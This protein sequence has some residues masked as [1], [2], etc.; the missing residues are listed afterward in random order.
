MYIFINLAKTFSSKM[1]INI[2]NHFYLMF[3]C[4][5]PTTKTH[6]KQLGSFMILVQYISLKRLE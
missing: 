2:N 1:Y 6:L 5:T 3:N 4:L